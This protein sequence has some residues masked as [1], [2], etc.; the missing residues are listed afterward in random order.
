VHS[1][2][3]L[4]EH[5]TFDAN[6]AR[7]GGAISLVLETRLHIYNSTFTRNQAD[8]SGGAIDADDFCALNVTDSSFNSNTAAD[9]GGALALF[10]DQSAVISGMQCTNN[11]ATDRGGCVYVSLPR[12]APAQVRCSHAAV[13]AL[14]AV[15]T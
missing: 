8:F 10:C 2:Q 14:Q 9:Q 7:W 4:I 5:C 15:T 3:A 11:T 13:L 12:A 1:L 6:R